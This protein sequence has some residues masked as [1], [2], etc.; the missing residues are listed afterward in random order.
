MLIDKL[1]LNWKE[2]MKDMHHKTNEFSLES[3]ITC[4]QIEEE[5]KKQDI[6]E[7]VLVVS[8][9]N[10]EKVYHKSHVVVVLKPTSMKMKNPTK[11]HNNNKNSINVKNPQWNQNKKIPLHEMR[12]LNHSCA[13]TMTTLG[14]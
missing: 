5:A 4:L 11:N 9:N 2:F 8:N 13:T 1:P 10:L 6:K 12:H 3:L 7:V 14:I